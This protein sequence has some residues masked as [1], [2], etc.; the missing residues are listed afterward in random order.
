[1][2]AKKGG[3]LRLNNIKRFRHKLNISQAALAYS[4]RVAQQAVAKW[5]AGES[6]PRA[7]RLPELARIL[8]CTIDE[9]FAEE[10]DNR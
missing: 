4:M 8:G 6:M 10:S 7:D 2:I 9:L 1:M 5:E 3:D